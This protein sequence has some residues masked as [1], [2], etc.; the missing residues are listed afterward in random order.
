[1]C[2]VV[3]QMVIEIVLKFLEDFGNYKYC[4]MILYVGMIVLNGM[5][6]MGYFG[7]WVF[8]MMEYVVLVV[9]DIFYVGGFVIL[10]LN[11]MRYMFDINVDCFKNFMFNMFD[12]DIEG[13]MDKEIVFEGID[14]L[15][16]FWLS[17]GVLFCFVDYDIGEDKFELIV[18][19]V[20]KEMEYGGFG[21]F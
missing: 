1:M 9:Y 18:D 6:Q 19:I 3:F 2:F 4:E 10:F 20:V 8:Y 11:W 15:L 13:K 16:V 5:L 7:D 17:F 21:N 12:I 14:K